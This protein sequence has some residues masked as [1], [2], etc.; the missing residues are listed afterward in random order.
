MG[1]RAPL[2]GEIQIGRIR[3]LA[4]ASLLLLSAS[5]CLDT[6]SDVRKKSS[7]SSTASPASSASSSSGLV[8]LQTLLK[9]RTT[10]ETQVDLIGQNGQIGKYCAPTTEAASSSPCRCA[11]QYK[12]LDKKSQELEL[13]PVL[14]EEDLIRCTYNS[15][16]GS[17]L[18]SNY[19]A[20][21]ILVRLRNSQ[22]YSGAL[23]DQFANALPFNPATG[24]VSANYRDPLLYV[25]PARHQ[26][27]DS[28]SLGMQLDSSMNDPFLADDP[29]L[30]YP[31][32][33]YAT[34]LGLAQFHFHANPSALPQ[35]G[36][37]W[38]CPFTPA[39]P[40]VGSESKQDFRLY[41]ATPETRTPNGDFSQGSVLESYQISPGN[42]QSFDRSRFT[43]ASRSV[44]RFSVPV[45]AF[46]APNSVAI[47]SEGSVNSPTGNSFPLG[48]AVKPSRI[49]AG[50]APGQEICPTQAEVDIDT[51]R[52]RWV[53]L[54]LMRAELRPRVLPMSNR[55]Q[56]QLA[57][58]SSTG[59]V[60]NPGSNAFPTVDC[61]SD[62]ASGFNGTAG[63][64]DDSL[65][66]RV[67][68]NATGALACLRYHHTDR[69]PGQI[70][71]GPGATWD[72]TTQ[73]TRP[74]YTA[75]GTVPAQALFGEGTDAVTFATLETSKLPGGANCGG[76]DATT[77]DPLGLCGNPVHSQLSPRATVVS[78]RRV[79]GAFSNRP[80]DSAARID[81]VFVVTPA[82]IPPKEMV[83]S[84]DMFSAGGPNSRALPYLPYRFYVPGS[85]LSTRPDADAATNPECAGTS[86]KR[87][88]YLPKT[89]DILTPESAQVSRVFPLC[90]LQEVAP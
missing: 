38:I 42:P 78:D 89:K 80:L 52:Y 11:F 55:L 68:L 73:S 25:S 5:A 39:S 34:N 9:S 74:P 48:Y 2:S 19:A 16:D 82:N 63:T 1:V 35:N 13:P 54:W 77:N 58:A 64:N 47:A 84:E 18:P 7:A 62:A 69:T 26:C 67:L 14:V 44:G 79:A 87:I 72:G 71:F 45:S 36:A 4:A 81:Y 27:W 28:L 76:K 59:V 50:T 3:L 40:Q 24:S 41:S 32:N 85:C 30:T 75:P 12:T 21:S 49:T 90:V 70:S 20:D 8:T 29:R 6:G 65:A 43:L 10:P 22:L 37:G 61:A 53:K 88:R 83:H 33:F 15:A 23:R 60:C 56:S 66:D 57:A 31:L 51:S 17:A 46:F 86:D